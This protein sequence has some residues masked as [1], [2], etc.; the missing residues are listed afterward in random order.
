MT[1]RASGG[2]DEASPG[3]RMTL[4]PISFDIVIALGQLP[5]G[6]RL[7]TLAHAIGSPVSS[8][9]AALRVLV[10]N[11]LAVRESEVP[12]RYRLS[13]NH[14]AHDALYQMSLLLPEAAHAMAIAVR[15]SPAVALAVVDKA[16]FVVGIAADAAADDRARLGASLDVVRAARRNAPLIEINDQDELVRHLAV[17][18]GLRD[19]V[20]RAVLL[21]GRIPRGIPVRARGSRSRSRQPVA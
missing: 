8:V 17:S 13:G 2:L 5:E 16:G 1:D 9:Q 10:A 21:K 12:P 20:I 14:P 7:S 3:R 15:A 19:R 18:V 4:T 11:G 6:V